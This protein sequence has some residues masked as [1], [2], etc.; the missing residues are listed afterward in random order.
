MSRVTPGP[1]LMLEASIEY[2]VSKTPRTPDL[3]WSPCEMNDAQGLGPRTGFPRLAS[4]T[5]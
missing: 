2:A 1:N 4:L 5:P 3:D